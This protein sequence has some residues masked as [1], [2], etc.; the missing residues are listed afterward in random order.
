MRRSASVIQEYQDKT[1][2]KLNQKNREII[3]LTEQLNAKDTENRNLVKAI[4]DLEAKTR[5][6]NQ[7]IKDLEDKKELLQVEV[8]AAHI[9]TQ[10]TAQKAAKNQTIL[11]NEIEAF[12]MAVSEKD[13][14][15]RNMAEQIHRLETDREAFVI[16][17]TDKSKS[18][19]ATTTNTIEHD[20]IVRDLNHQLSQLTAENLE[21]NDMKKIYTDELNCLKINLTSTEELHKQM[22]ATITTLRASSMEHSKRAEQY[23]A[24]LKS[25]REQ[26]D[27][28][29]AQVDV[30]RTD[31]QQERSAREKLVN[32]K[33]NIITDL[34]L[35][36]KRNK[37]LIDDAQKRLSS[38][39]VEPQPGPSRH[40]GA[41]KK[42]T[43]T[44]SN[45]SRSPE[46][47]DEIKYVCPICNQESE[48]LAK[49]EQHIEACLKE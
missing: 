34:Q 13:A 3:D 40:T 49:L 11:E 29:N 14:I 35:L 24:E 44:E 27:L 26:I 22:Q 36:Q 1:K 45:K 5:E 23:A 47:Q 21:F 33:E 38:S 20:R 31:F 4:G 32:E 15:I 2:Q 16:V 18:S 42:G 48:N 8:K 7:I 46:K 19:L 37:E 43:S 12:K 30:Y 17:G 39:P 41:I 10:E 28:L 9:E 6:L 25:A